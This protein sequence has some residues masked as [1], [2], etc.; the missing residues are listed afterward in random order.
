MTHF[1]EDEIPRT[2]SL[3]TI[4]KEIHK[5]RSALFIID[6]A[7]KGECPYAMYYKDQKVRHETRLKKEKEMK[8]LL[9][10]REIIKLTTPK[11]EWYPKKRF[12]GRYK[13]SNVKIRAEIM[14]D[15]WMAGYNPKE[16]AGYFKLNLVTVYKYL[17]IP[18]LKLKLKEKRLEL[19]E[20]KV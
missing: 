5:R 6:K 4:G 13:G 7:E 2:T 14:R 10:E 16:I 15:T 20:G 17:K 9:A 3:R 8:A 12:C 18:Y 19:L 11:K 1:T